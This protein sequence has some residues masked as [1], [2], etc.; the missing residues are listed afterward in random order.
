MATNGIVSF[1]ENG[2]VKTKIIVG[3]DGYNAEQFAIAS[4]HK[5]FEK[6]SDYYDFA[7]ANDF[8]CRGCLVVMNSEEHIFIGDGEIIP[9]LY[10]ATF[11]V[12]FVN[13]R[14]TKGIASNVIKINQTR[15]RIY[16]FNF[17]I[18]KVKID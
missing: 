12:W 11:N 9:D 17:D 6:L 16:R 1:T 15:K 10:Y 2:D 4:L 7:L 5:K 14:W 18:Q 13:P 3:C 8:G